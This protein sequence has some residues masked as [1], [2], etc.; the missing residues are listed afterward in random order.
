[1]TELKKAGASAILLG[2]LLP[3]LSWLT[4]STLSKSSEHAERIN[5][6]ESRSEYNR[7]T[8][9]EIKAGIDKLNDKIDK[10]RERK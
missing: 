2:M 7:D 3:W 1:M 4:L 9:N 10:M 6:V 5:R 8:L